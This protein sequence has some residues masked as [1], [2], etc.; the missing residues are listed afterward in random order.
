MRHAFFTVPRLQNDEKSF[1]SFLYPCDISYF[2]GLI[3]VPEE[4]PSYNSLST[5]A[6][7]DVRTCSTT[8][9]QDVLIQNLS[10]EI[11]VCCLPLKLTCAHF[12]LISLHNLTGV[13]LGPS[14][15]ENMVF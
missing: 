10:I 4:T 14:Q 8:W 2:A 9:A 6:A 3:N 12:A 7:Y 13:I 15:V 11:I 5:D 1:L